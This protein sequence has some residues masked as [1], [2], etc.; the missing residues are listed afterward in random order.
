MEAIAVVPAVTK[1]PTRRNLERFIEATGKTQAEYEAWATQVGQRM[2]INTL[3]RLVCE[4]LGI[5]TVSHLAHL[6]TTV[7]DDAPD[8]DAYL[9]EHS[10]NPLELA[11][12]WR[13]TVAEAGKWMD[14]EAWISENL[15]RF[16]KEDFER[17]GDANW[18]VD[19]SKSWFQKDGANLDV[20]LGEMN[21]TRPLKK[22]VKMDDVIAFVRAHK[23]G[24]YVNPMERR[25]KDIERRFRELTTFGLKDYYAEH[26]VRMAYFTQRHTDDQVPF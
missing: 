10:Q 13:R 18:L 2:H 24:G 25:M 15:K 12:L 5:Y 8:P 17:F 20:Q 3:D 14:V 26:L 22:K 7:P 6:T 16:P 23:P 19:V 21:A 4:K 11:E 9:A 1:A